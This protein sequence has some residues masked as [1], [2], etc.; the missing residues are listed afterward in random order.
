MKGITEW[1]A[2]IGLSE[3]AQPF[4]DNAIDL[5]VVRHLTEQDLKDL[6][7]PL[8]HR[9]KMLRA[10]AELNPA[11]PTR[12]EAERRLLTV[13]FCDL[14]GSAALAAR[15]D[16]EDMWG[17]IASYHACIGEV[18]APY[19][20]MIARYMGDGVLVYFGYPRAQEDEA[21]QA[22]RAALALVDAVPNLRTKAEA[23]LQVRIGIATGTVVVSEL[24][25]DET[26]AEKAVIG[27]TPNLAARLQTLAEPGTVLICPQTH[28]LT[29]GHFDYR[30]LGAIA[31]KGWAEPV[32]V[33]Q[34]L[35]PTGVASRFEAMHK[36]KLP[37]LFGREEEIEL[38]L[39]RWRYASQGEGRVVVLTGEPGI[40][41]SHIALALEERLE[42]QPHI[43]LRYFCSAHHTN[44]ALFPFIG[45]L[46]RAAGFERTDSVME[47]LSKLDALVA[48]STADSEHVAVLANLLALP[49][50][51]RYQ[52]QELSPQKRKEKTLAALLAQLDGLAGRQPVLIIFEDIHWIDPTSLELLTAT[53]EHVPQIRVLLLA[54][55]RPEF[56]LPWPSYPH[57]TTVPLTRLGRREGA[58]LVERVTNGK[59]LPKEVM[60]EILA[61]TD[62]I[63]LFIEELTKT[64]LESG[65]LQEQNGNYVL[66][67]P[68]PALAIP[69]TLH[70]SLMAR[71]DRLA[72]V[73]EVAQIGAVAG[74]EFH[75]EL[76]NA[77]AGLPAERLEEAL[78][79]LVRS[80]L[81][82]RRG[83]IPHAIY[84]FKHTLVRD[85]AYAGLLKSRRVYLHAAIASALEQ[86]FPE[87][88]QTQPETL[89]HHLTEAGLIEQAIRYWLEAGKNAALRSANLEAISHLRRGIEGTGRLPASQDRDRSELDVELVLGPCLIATQGPGASE[90][91][92]TFARARELCERLG[93]PP[94]YLQVMFWLATVSVVRGE[95][96]QALEAVATLLSAAEARDDRPAL[97]NATRGRAMILFFL[98]RIVEAREAIERAVELFSVSR[99]AD[100][101]AARAAGQDA[102]VAMLALSSW[103]LWVL[104][105]VD[106]AVAQ[107]D[108]ALER[109]NAVQHAHTHAYAWYYASVLH[110]LRGEATIAQAYAE[111]CL[112][113]SEQHGFRQWLGLSRAIRG[114]CA[115]MLDAS[116][117]RFDE[118]TTA[119]DEYQRAGYQLGITAQFVLACP[120]LL[121]R[122]EAAAAL[123]L[124]DQGFS[125]VSH[126]SERCFEAE[127]YRLKARAILMRGASD[128]EAESLLDQALRIARSQQARSLELRAATDLARL[129]MQQ[130]KHVEA[131][132]VLTSIHS[133]FTEGFDTRDVKEARAVL[134]QLQ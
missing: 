57:M 133:R 112:A 1:L 101:M 81:I 79:Q 30:D 117:S 39:R 124:I 55:A 71:L 67:R 78:G 15:L 61:R 80:E 48:Q 28:R 114:I 63:P 32:P 20:G 121:V 84:T 118:V 37:P 36:T 116:S 108:A 97:I 29:A 113:I 83:E 16:P 86:R 54:T 68:L 89:A 45:Q 91:V 76:I 77:V 49:T 2:S 90:A 70:A 35:R 24:S 92:T 64:V 94:E 60:D 42:S 131:V 18:V 103:V 4:A 14:V 132:D 26:P 111:R 13:M 23:A 123:E 3:Y 52:L 31:L 87:I 34:V 129:W 59:R 19:E 126:N 110:T 93:K 12:D 38:L 72:P 33:W 10:I 43:T 107:M 44:S 69:T 6:G 27:E 56:T 106:G 75:Y 95:L 98:G 130:G 21:E 9:R 65:L 100:R 96:P 51:G 128:A 53:V 119:L 22:V 125:I 41:K 99:D 73:R 50:N 11:A 120:G 58:A 74:R 8:G 62:G 115:A 134:A 109:A 47:K 104:G 46:E 66:E 17:V 25:I 105:Q 40:G 82:F 7:V 5:S 127:L 88:V 122:N 102:G 85:A